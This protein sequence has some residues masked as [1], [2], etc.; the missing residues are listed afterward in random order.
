MGNNNASPTFVKFAVQPIAV[1]SLVCK[2]VIEVDAVNEWWNSNGIVSVA[3][4][5]HKAHQ[6]A[7]GISQR[8]DFGR[9][10]TF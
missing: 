7:K 1:E 8:E 3:G 9:P 2:Q 5:E 6:I 4:Q 10:A